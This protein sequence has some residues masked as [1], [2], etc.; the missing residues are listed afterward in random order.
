MWPRAV[1]PFRL[2]NSTINKVDNRHQQEAALQVSRP[3]TT[4]IR[5]RRCIASCRSGRVR[6]GTS[7]QRC[8]VPWP[9]GV[10]EPVGVIGAISKQPPRPGQA[11]QPGRSARV[12]ADLACRYEQADQTSDRASHSVKFGV[13]APLVRPISRPM[14]LFT[15]GLEVVRCASCRSSPFDARSPG[16]TAPASS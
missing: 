13:H 9:A 5:L 10:P 16:R 3:T 1:P 2:S 6:F 11:V 7:G 12:V 4:S 8:R 15:R 14:P